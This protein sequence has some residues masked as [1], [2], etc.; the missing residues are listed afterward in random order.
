[1]LL[2]WQLAQQ[3]K[4]GVAAGRTGG[5]GGDY[6]I[7]LS[8]GS[9]QQLAAYDSV[10]QAMAPLYGPCVAPPLPWVSPQRGC[11]ALS[12]SHHHR[13]RVDLMRTKTPAQGRALAQ[14]HRAGTHAAGDAADMMRG[15]TQE[16]APRSTQQGLSQ[17]YHSLNVLSSQAWSINSRVLEV[18]G[19]HLPHSCLPNPAGMVGVLCGE[20]AQGLGP[21]RGGLLKLSDPHSRDRGSQL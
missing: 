10:V 13:F 1:M 11:Y 21:L 4:C 3:G 20:G 8:G 9:M 7:E 14:A 16:G 5:S 18:R 12:H 19:A 6:G 2:R 17:L 15:W